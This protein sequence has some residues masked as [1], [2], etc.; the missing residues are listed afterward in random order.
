MKL[1][2]FNEP[3]GRPRVGVALGD[4]VVDVTAAD[5]AIPADMIGFLEAGADARA[6][7]DA[8]ASGGAP[9]FALAEVE[10][11]S[12]VP[13]P[14]KILAV[15]LNYGDHIAETG[16]DTPEIPMIFNKQS[17]SA[18]GPAQP[19][20]RPKVS[21]KLD[22]EGELAIVIGR[23]CRHVPKDRAADV[24][25]G[26]TVCN[27]VSVR[28]WQMRS[29]TF[30]MGKSFDTHCP[31]GP[32]IVTSDEVGDPHALDLKTWVNGE[33]RQSS[34]TKHLVFDCYDLVEHLSTAFTLEPGDVI[35]TGT[36][37]GIGAA[38]KPRQYLKAG[39]VVRVEIEGIGAIENAVIEEPESTALY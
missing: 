33:L 32:W 21:D 2:T 25:A 22:Y 12:P 29:A 31:L 17:T 23:R 16:L 34:N 35:P 24:I 15:G 20:H 4:A 28:D 30:T 13:R 10:L 26:Y 27:D 7:A 9:R 1:V 39:D 36:P 19:F 14:G 3:G 8:A 11:H 38:M 6:A 37:G 18:H 5:A